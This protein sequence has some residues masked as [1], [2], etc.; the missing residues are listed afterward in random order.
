METTKVGIREFRSDMADYIAASTPVAVTRHGQTVA[1][2]IPVHGVADAEL[3]ALKRAGAALD[4]LMQ[5]HG[6]DEDALVTEFAAA[7]RGAKA[8]AAP[9]SRATPRVNRPSPRRTKAAAL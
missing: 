9:A 3:A 5:A 7:R 6:V 8:A 1:Y 2:F 4:K